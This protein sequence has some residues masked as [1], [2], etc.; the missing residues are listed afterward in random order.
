MTTFTGF[1]KA[2]KLPKEIQLIQKMMVSLSMMFIS[3]FLKND[4]FVQVGFH[5]K[6]TVF[7]VFVRFTAAFGCHSL[8]CGEE[9]NQAP[10]M[11][12]TALPKSTLVV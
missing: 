11:V 3:K 10:I 1:M 9:S 2:V 7:D 12:T 8:C 5:L 4:L 6:A